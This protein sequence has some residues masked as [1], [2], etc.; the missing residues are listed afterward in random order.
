MVMKIIENLK[1]GSAVFHLEKDARRLA[2]LYCTISLDTLLINETK[3]QNLPDLNFEDE[4][5]M[6]VMYAVNFAMEKDLKIKA[7]CPF[8]ISIFNSNPHIGN[9]IKK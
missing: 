4:G 3:G 7:S 1:P 8:A 5:R 2:S 9:N 6:L